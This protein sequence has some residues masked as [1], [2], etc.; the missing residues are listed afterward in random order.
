MTDASDTDNTLPRC[1]CGAE[2]V[3]F[4]SGSE[5]DVPVG[6]V[7]KRGEPWRARCISCLNRESTPERL[8]GHAAGATSD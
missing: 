5:H 1:P 8:A 7:I 3:A 4:F 6:I 2:A